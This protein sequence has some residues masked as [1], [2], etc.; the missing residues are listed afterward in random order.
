VKEWNLWHKWL[1]KADA[2]FKI[3]STTLITPPMPHGAHI[4]QPCHIVPHFPLPHF[5]SSRNQLQV[6]CT[7]HNISTS[8]GFS[9]VAESP[10]LFTAAAELTLHM[11]VKPKPCSFIL[12]TT[13]L[14]GARTNS[15][16]GGAHVW[17]QKNVFVVPL[18]FFGSMS[19][20]TEIILLLINSN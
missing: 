2:K 4:F 12:C 17:C 15:K 18:H 9:L 6:M 5:Q 11:K 8:C 10:S 16:V 13:A 7:G 1:R 19:I 20:L 14:S 3:D